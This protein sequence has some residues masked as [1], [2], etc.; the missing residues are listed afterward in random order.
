M[1]LAPMSESAPGDDFSFDYLSWNHRRPAAPFSPESREREHQ[2]VYLVGSWEQS[3]APWRVT[4][5]SP[6]QASGSSSPRGLALRT[7][8]PRQGRQQ[9]VDGYPRVGLYDRS[10]SGF[11][12]V[13]PHDLNPGD[14]THPR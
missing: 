4:S 2:R 1:D 3:S 6:A 9:P 13:V 10:E 14:G 5:P 8:E 12:T 7:S 11:R